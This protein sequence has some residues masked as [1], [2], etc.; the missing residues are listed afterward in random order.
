MAFLRQ[1]ARGDNS[2]AKSKGN[3]R[4]ETP[5]TAEEVRLAPVSKISTE[6]HHKHH[7]KNRKRGI[8]SIFTLGGIFGIV[9]AGIFAQKSD[10]IEFPEIGELTL[11]SIFDVL[12]AGFV[13]DARDLAVSR[14]LSRRIFA[15]FMCANMEL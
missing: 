9:V 4:E 6:G 11:D 8:F 7:S 10:L 1:R 5:E 12:P 3:E 2:E 13:R 14:L 15:C